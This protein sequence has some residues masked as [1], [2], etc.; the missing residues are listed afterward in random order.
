MRKPRVYLGQGWWVVALPWEE[1]R[2]LTFE[3]QSWEGAMEWLERYG[4]PAVVKRGFS[5]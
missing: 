3:F 2:W 4:M 1:G 5:A